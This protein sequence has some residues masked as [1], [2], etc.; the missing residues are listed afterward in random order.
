MGGQCN[1]DWP[2][3]GQSATTVLAHVCNLKSDVQ[4]LLMYSKSSEGDATVAKPI[5]HD[6]FKC[7]SD[8]VLAFL[9]KINDQPSLKDLAEAIELVNQTTQTILTGVQASKHVHGGQAAATTMTAPAAAQATTT[10]VVAVEQ[11]ADLPEIPPKMTVD[12]KNM[13]PEV[14]EKIRRRG[15]AALQTRANLAG[16]GA[17]PA[18][19]KAA[20][21][22]PKVG[23]T[24][25][26]VLQSQNTEQGKYPTA[27]LYSGGSLCALDVVKGAA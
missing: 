27:P 8:S 19:P 9:E 23:G 3:V 25:M 5:P 2:V 14:A 26:L 6:V 10:T 13:P 24:T 21:I 12:M 18:G 7:F 22:T 4:K 1:T 17:R 15:Q 20:V 11:Q 16:G